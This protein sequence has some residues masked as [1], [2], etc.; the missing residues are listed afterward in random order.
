MSPLLPQVMPPIVKRAALVADQT[1][2]TVV[3]QMHLTAEPTTP[4]VAGQARRPKM[5]RPHVIAALRGKQVDRKS[6]R[7]NS[8]HSCASSIPYSAC[9]ITSLTNTNLIT[10]Q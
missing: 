7:L 10:S 6:T 2:R 8:S 9:K 3:E 5:V 4:L 1:T